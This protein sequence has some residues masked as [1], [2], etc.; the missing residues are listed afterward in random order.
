MGQQHR[1]GGATTP[2]RHLVAPVR[3]HTWPRHQIRPSRVSA[4]ARHG[5]HPPLE[6]GSRAVIATLPC[7]PA[8]EHPVG[9]RQTPNK[10]HSEGPRFRST[11]SFRRGSVRA[12]LAQLLSTRRPLSRALAPAAPHPKDPLRFR[13]R[14]RPA[15][16]PDGWHGLVHVRARGEGRSVGRVATVVITRARSRIALRPYREPS[17]PGTR[18][19]T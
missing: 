7:L 4:A 19:R 18:A 8:L 13:A 14:H 16:R 12:G 15:A 1:R 10:P 2:L 17:V 11:G 5:P 6:V 3:T 9:D